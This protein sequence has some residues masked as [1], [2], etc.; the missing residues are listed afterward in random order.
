MKRMNRKMQ[1]AKYIA[2][3][4]NRVNKRNEKKNTVKHGT[5]AI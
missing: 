2:I 3:N 1:N 4:I 5:A